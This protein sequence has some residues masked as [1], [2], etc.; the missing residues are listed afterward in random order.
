LRVAIATHQQI[1]AVE[2]QPY[3]WVL[4][5]FWNLQ[6]I[7]RQDAAMRAG[8]REELVY[9]IAYAHHQPNQ[10]DRWRYDLRRNVGLLE[11]AESAKDRAKRIA[12]K[13]QQ[14]GTGGWTALD[15]GAN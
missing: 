9:G 15:D 12:D 4:W 5:I 8:E 2:D 1:G 14:H 7:E 13:M 10:L 11:K 3:A 6:L